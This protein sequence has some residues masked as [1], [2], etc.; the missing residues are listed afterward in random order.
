MD[1]ETVSFI[2]A[3]IGIIVAIF[4]IGFLLQVII[5]IIPNTTVKRIVAIVFW[6]AFLPA[7]LAMWSS[8]RVTESERTLFP[9]S[10]TLRNRGRAV[11]ISLLLYAFL[12]YKL[13][14]I[15]F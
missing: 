5:H 6:I 7:M 11:F 10:I 12:Y 13:F 3:V 2:L 15:I 14:S 4:A 8:E 9:F 1:G